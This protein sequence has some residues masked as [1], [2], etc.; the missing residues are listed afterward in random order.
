MS[1]I[2]G[3][4]ALEKSRSIYCQPSVNKRLHSSLMRAVRLF[5]H[6]VPKPPD[7]VT[8]AGIIQQLFGSVVALPA[9]VEKGYMDLRLSVAS[10]GGHSSIPPKHT[11]RE[12]TPQPRPIPDASYRASAFWLLSLLR[13]KP[14]L[15]PQSYPEVFRSL[16]YAARLL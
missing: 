6:S 15:F 4:R 5:P 3:D 16:F 11:V 2:S 14:I 1:F 10:P 12:A 7:N 9:V 8:F 13:L